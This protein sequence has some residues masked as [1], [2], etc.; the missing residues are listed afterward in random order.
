MNGEDR[1]CCKTSTLQFF[2][3]NLKERDHRRLTKIGKRY[4]HATLSKIATYFSAATSTSV[5]VRTVN[6][7][8]LIWLSETRDHS[9][10]SLLNVR[11]KYLRISC[12]QHRTFD[13]WT[14]E[15]RF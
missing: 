12:D 15:S 6:D 11:H 4:R 2:K 10:I 14:N 3:Q 8:T 1:V 7:I 9:C 13:D 5:S